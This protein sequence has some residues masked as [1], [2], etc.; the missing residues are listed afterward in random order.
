MVEAGNR[1]F[2]QDID[3]YRIV[4]GVEFS[5]ED[6]DVEAVG[7]TSVE[8]MELIRT[9]DGSFEAACS[10]HLALTVTGSCVPL[11]LFGGPGTI[12]QDQIDYIS[13]TGTAKTTYEQNHSK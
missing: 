3:T 9:K 2:I 6:W 1:N 10:R 12:T 4:G 8:Q 11:N 7:T 13:Y 5:L